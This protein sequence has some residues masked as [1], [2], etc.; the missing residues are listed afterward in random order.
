MA[1]NE[2]WKTYL[3]SQNARIEGDDVRDFGDAATERPGGGLARDV[4][5]AVR[6]FRPDVA[7]AHF[8]VPAGLLAVLGGR[9]PTVV[10]AHGQDVENAVRSRAV[11]VSVSRRRGARCRQT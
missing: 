11:T 6:R 5:G 3:Q 7:Y 4:V 2:L 8:L 10:T 1:M 9:A